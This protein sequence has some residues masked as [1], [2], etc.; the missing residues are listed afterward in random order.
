[1]LMTSKKEVADQIRTAVAAVTS[2]REFIKW[3]K[4]E[5]VSDGLVLLNNSFIFGRN[6]KRTRMISTS[7]SL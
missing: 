3:I 7:E 1:M 5:E 6:S 2:Q 4:E